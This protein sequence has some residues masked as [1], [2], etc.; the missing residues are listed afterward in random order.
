MNFIYFLN[1]FLLGIALAMDACAVS[2]AN[3]LNEPKIL[4]KKILGISA[5]FGLFQ[6]AMPLLG[7][8]IGHAFIEYIEKFIPWISLILLLFLG[9]KAIIEA[10][11]EK[12]EEEKNNQHITLK[13]VFV[14]AI[15]TS[16]DALSVGLTI[17]DYKLIEAIVTAIII[18]VITTLICIAAHFI[19]KK[20]GTKL[21]N[22]AEILGGI[23]L[24]IIGLEIFFTGIF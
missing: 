16:I 9:I 15:A 20:F 3:G 13:L 22:K 1:S 14:Q 8:L 24:I 6:G 17:S 21:G 23:I 11:R 19:G 12:D 10:V 7:Y 18:A 2:M 5:L 4:L